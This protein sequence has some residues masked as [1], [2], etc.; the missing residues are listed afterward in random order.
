MNCYFCQ[1][2][3]TFMIENT[4]NSIKYLYLLIV[5]IF[6]ILISPVFLSKGMFLDGL[7]YATI[8]RNLSIGLGSYWDLFY[9]NFNDSHFM[10]HPPLVFWIE[11]SLFKIFGDSIYV[12]KIYSVLTIVISGILLIFLWNIITDKKET[13]SSWLPL[14]IFVIFPVTSWVAVNN[15]L[16]N[17]MMIFDLLSIIFIFLSF[18]E[19]HIINILISVLF[20]VLAVMSKGFPALFPISAFFFTWL[21]LKKI[22]FK[23]C[24]F[25]TVLISLLTVFP[26]VL[27][28]YFNDNAHTYFITYFDRQILGTIRQTSSVSKPYSILQDLI[29]QLIFP[30][31][32][33]IISFIINKKKIRTDKRKIDYKQSL[34]FFLIALSGV[35]P[36]ML[37]HKQRSFYLAPILPFL[38]ISVALLLNELNDKFILLLKSVKL[39]KYFKIISLTILFIS[40]IFMF[41][42]VGKYGRDK[43]AQQDY[44][45]IAEI[46][47]RGSDVSISTELY[48]NWTMYAYFMRYYEISIT[49]SEMD[50]KI[51]LK[52]DTVFYDN[53][54]EV[55]VELQNYKLLKRMQ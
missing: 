20:L 13:K 9:T 11:G 40:V 44:A 5:G 34:L 22:S 53:Y 49:T 32:L 52:S 36:M 8:S 15:M 33:I 25:D 23:R 29:N 27:L 50:Y 18:R 16:E 26:F 19:N 41:S 10:S 21:I 46:T 39:K 28:Y 48:D 51:I 31:V 1:Q 24:V 38:A 54:K 14:F 2:K 43:S 3:I 47:K 37:S 4:N 55:P 30:V 12:E 7:Y 6:I 35:V 17:T 45:K 42:R